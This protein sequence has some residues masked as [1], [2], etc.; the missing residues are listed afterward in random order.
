MRNIDN[1]FLILFFIFFCI[2]R[3][4]AQEVAYW[5]DKLATEVATTPFNEIRERYLKEDIAPNKALAYTSLCL[6]KFRE[7]NQKELMFRVFRDIGFIYENNNNLAEALNFYQQAEQLP[8]LSDSS[9]VT[10]YIDL[11]IVQRKMCHYKQCK[12]DYDKIIQLATTIND[13]ESIEYAYNGIGYLYEVTADYEQ[14]AAYYLKSLS[15]AEHRNNKIGMATSKQNIANIM[16]LAKNY[17][18]ALRNSEQA[19]LLAIETKDTAAI[20]NILGD[21]GLILS[22]NGQYDEAIKKYNQGLVL[23]GTANYKPYIAKILLN[24]ADVYILKGENN[25]AEYYLLQCLNDFLPYIYN[26]DLGNLYLKVG[27]LYINKE[28]DTQAAIAYRK[29]LAICEKYE[30]KET[31]AKIAHALS[32]TEQR[33]GNFELSL[34]FLQKAN[35]IEDS[36][37]SEASIKRTAELQFK[38]DVAKGEQEIQDL[39]LKQNTLLFGALGALFIITV[40]FFVISGRRKTQSNL[41]LLNKNAEIELQNR[42]LEESNTALREFAYASAHDLKEPLRNIGSFISLLQRR[43]GKTFN[44]E[45]NEYIGYVNKGV[46]KMNKL[47]E[48]LLYYSTLVVDKQAVTSES[49]CLSEV[50]EEV[51]NSLQVTIN[52]TKARIECPSHLPELKMS[53]IHQ[54]QLFQNL[55]SNAL[56]FVEETPIIHINAYDNKEHTLISIADNGIGIK[57]EYS[58][59]VFKLFNR[60]N[61]T[62]QNEGSGIG[63]T[64]CKSIVDKYNGKIW[65]ESVEEKGTTFF[66]Q[67]PKVA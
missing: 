53:R 4:E 64:I 54:T 66:I 60:L 47:L 22:K 13:V 8:A 1:R 43:Y 21:Y 9:L 45:A 33:L 30:L 55:L 62:N 20:A 67:L 32:K 29:G 25:K 31:G 19:Y 38:F 61:R 40:L 48:D 46:I 36:L 41:I 28:R 15:V 2:F 23:F 57:Q 37:F 3:S 11:A 17:Q 6:E 7:N 42:R 39:K 24:I 65:F 44:E 50:L 34:Q 10:I 16:V 12:D 56:K 49:I 18:I 52:T 26:E 14:S 59:K 35:A 58:D 27:N 5:K 51:K 63:L